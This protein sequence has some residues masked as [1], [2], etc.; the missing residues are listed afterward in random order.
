M[1]ALLGEAHCLR[2]YRYW[3][4]CCNWGD[5]PYFAEA[6]KAGM[7][8]DL[9]KTDK[10]IIFTKEI[11]ALVDHEEDMPFSDVAPAGVERMNR[12]LL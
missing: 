11:Q 3:M 4:L 2:A 6:A 5:V 1:K 12:D 8:L 9:P 10:N 7:E